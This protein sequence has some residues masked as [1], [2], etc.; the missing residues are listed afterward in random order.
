MSNI[1]MTSAS[2]KRGRDVEE[3]SSE[4]MPLSKRINNLH[5]NSLSVLQQ[6]TM[7][8]METDDWGSE[9]FV[10]SPSCSEVSSNSPSRDTCSS[11]QSS[12]TTE[13]RPDLDAMSNPFYYESNKLLF[14]LYMERMQRRLNLY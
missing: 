10:P 14:S 5:I 3:E 9:N 4:F 12:L 1:T 2:R 6:R 8:S 7:E 13:Y 11:S